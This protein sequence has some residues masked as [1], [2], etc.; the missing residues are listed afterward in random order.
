MNADEH[1]W[2]GLIDPEFP[3]RS[4]P[5]ASICVHLRFKSCRNSV[6]PC[7]PCCFG[8][9]PRG[10]PCVQEA[11]SATPNGRARLTPLERTSMTRYRAAILGCGGRGRAHAAGYAASSQAEIVGCADPWRR[12]R[13]PWR[14]L[15]PARKVYSDYRAL[16]KEQHP[17]VVSICTWPHLHREMVE[18]AIEAEARKRSTARSR[19]RRLRARPA[20]CTGPPRRAGAVDDF[21][22]SAPLRP[23]VPV[24]ARDL[25]REGAI[26]ELDRWR[27]TAPTCSTGARTGSTCSDFFNEETPAA[28]VMGQIDITRPAPGL[29]RAGR[30]QRRQPHRLGERCLGAADHRPPAADAA[31]GKQAWSSSEGW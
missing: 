30:D 12:M 10:N 22:P 2:A 27:A 24:K 14:R 31:A 25:V 3:V 5:S 17:D 29:R 1:R 8:M 23:L 21:L 19:W 4:V 6:S 20:R 26:G 9:P 16:L 11:V 15:T 7:P 18:A 13:A 28:W